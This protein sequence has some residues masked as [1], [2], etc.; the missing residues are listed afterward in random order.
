[1][2]ARKTAFAVFN[3]ES[4]EAEFKITVVDDNGV[5]EGARVWVDQERA[6]AVGTPKDG[7]VTLKVPKG[8]HVIHVTARGI[9]V[10][11]PYHV[12]KAKIHEMTINLVWERRQEHVSRALERQVD[13][14]LP[15]LTVSRKTPGGS[16]GAATSVGQRP[17]ASLHA[18]PRVTG[19]A[20]TAP[21]TEDA[22]EIPPAG[23]AAVG[24]PAGSMQGPL[25]PPHASAAPSTAAQSTR[26]PLPSA[27][28]A[29]ASTVF[30]Q[31]A[32]RPSPA[33]LQPAAGAGRMTLRPLARQSITPSPSE[34]PVDLNAPVDLHPHPTSPVD[35]GAPVDLGPSGPDRPVD[36][37]PPAKPRRTR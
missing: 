9:D 20:A 26:A 32:S 1:V 7:N 11:R 10:E 33:R 25:G 27:H 35:L 13:D 37:A 12:I 22:I 8:Y 14:A 6:R 36:L 24:S 3:L 15:Y 17:S 29:F 31:P 23:G 30:A 19:S 28:L 21:A 34:P 4:S 2:L 5:V 16:P 18:A